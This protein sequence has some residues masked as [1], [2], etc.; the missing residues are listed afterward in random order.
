M[1][2]TPS[3][4]SRISHAVQKNRPSLAAGFFFVLVR[5]LHPAPSLYESVSSSPNEVVG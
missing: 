5:V 2:P 4:A 3:A 1:N